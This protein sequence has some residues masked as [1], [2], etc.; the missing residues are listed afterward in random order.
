[1][2]S[3]SVQTS[4]A[5]LLTQSRITFAILRTTLLFFHLPTSLRLSLLLVLQ[6]RLRRLLCTYNLTA[7]I[8]RHILYAQWCSDKFGTGENSE[9]LFP[10][11]LH[12][13]ALPSTPLPSPLFSPPILPPLPSLRSRPLKSS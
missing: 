9:V 4:T 11:P 13:L 3:H 5:H 12:S 10:L 6:C 8:K 7:F 1:M 2:A